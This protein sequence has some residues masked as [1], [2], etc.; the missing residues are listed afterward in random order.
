MIRKIAFL[1]ILLLATG[2]MPS[3][4]ATPPQEPVQIGFYSVTPQIEWSR[5]MMTASE[6]WTVDGFAL[7]SLRFLEVADGQTLSGREDPEGKAP[8]FHKTMLPNEI[9]EFV[10]ETLA[11]GGWA[12]VKPKGLKPAKFGD[13]PGFR[14]SFGMLSE[15][16]LEYDG[17]ALGTV[18]EGTLHIIVYMGT[19]L[20][21]F[22]KYAKDVEKLFASIH[23]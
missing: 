16:G 18:R 7:E 4:V 20:H 8:V 12:N 19:R 3:I 5:P 9:Q 17:L 2:C 13:L 22:P 23:T 21:Y 11:T 6:V 15:D 1:A 14:F 10:V